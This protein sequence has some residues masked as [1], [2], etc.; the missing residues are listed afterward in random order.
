MNFAVELRL[1][2]AGRGPVALLGRSA[3]IGG[4]KSIFACLIRLPGWPSKIAAHRAHQSY[5]AYLGASLT[6]WKLGLER[7]AAST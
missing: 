7:D 4:L 3:G 5:F 1:T 2:S 6:L